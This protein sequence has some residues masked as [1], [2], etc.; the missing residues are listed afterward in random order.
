MIA[1][2]AAFLKRVSRGLIEYTTLRAA[3]AFARVALPSAAMND[4]ESLVFSQFWE[5]S[6]LTGFDLFYYW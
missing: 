3:A 1:A 6:G 5:F 4:P 2:Y